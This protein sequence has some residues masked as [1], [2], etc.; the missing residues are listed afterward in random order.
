MTV[1]DFTAWLA[2]A[3]YTVLWNHRDV[4]SATL[5]TCYIINGKSL[6]MRFDA[7]GLAVPYLPSVSKDCLERYELP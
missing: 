5:T 2:S 4:P 6:L 7:D 1:Q 3:D